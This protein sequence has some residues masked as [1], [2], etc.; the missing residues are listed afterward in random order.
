MEGWVDLG[1]P[2]THRPGVELAISR[3]QV[4]RPNHYT[5]EPPSSLRTNFTVKNLNCA[6]NAKQWYRVVVSV[7]M[8]RSRDGLKTYFSNVSV[9]SRSRQSV[10]RSRSQSRLGLKAKRLGLVS[11]SGHSVSFTSGHLNIFFQFLS[12]SYSSSV[13]LHL[14]NDDSFATLRPLALQQLFSATCSSA[15]NERVFCQ[16]GL[17]MRPTRFRL[18]PSRLVKLVF[19][20]CNKHSDCGHVN[21]WQIWL[22]SGWLDFLK[23]ENHL[24]LRSVHSIMV[25]CANRGTKIM[26]I[27]IK[28]VCLLIFSPIFV[29]NM[30]CLCPTLWGWTPRI[31]LPKQAIAE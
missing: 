25:S 31:L 14:F 6:L 9:S 2:V 28:F 5:T 8:S 13:G 29:R 17:I 16:S 7:S 24:T 10:G 1:Y 22:V 11:V 19:L 21:G 20:K 26:H 4:R 15:A 12:F 27:F 23:N 30:R 3:S 18:S